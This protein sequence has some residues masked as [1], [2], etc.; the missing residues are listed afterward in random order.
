MFYELREYHCQPGKR[1]EWVKLM[2]EE[3]IPYQV[4]KGMVVVASFVAEQDDD[5]YIWIR[6]FASE[7]ERVALY[8]A[9]YENDFWQND[10]SPRI[11]N[12]LD[13]SRTKVTRLVATPKSVI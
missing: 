5:T 3:I 11:G 1:D 12:L 2:E 9:V 10:M 6:R 8:K 13:R 4:S 7:E